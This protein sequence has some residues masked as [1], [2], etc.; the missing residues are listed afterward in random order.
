MRA[1]LPRDLAPNRC[2][3]RDG[4]ARRPVAAPR[5]GG[6]AAFSRGV[7]DEPPPLIGIAVQG[8]ASRAVVVAVG[9]ER[10]F[11]ARAGRTVLQ[12]HCRNADID[13]LFVRAE[14]VPSTS[15]TASWTA[16]SR[17]WT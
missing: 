15:K 5:R 12:S 8:S 7:D 13:L 1:S 6:Y 4:H 10:R 11:A 9:G 16:E 14:D 3:H 17:A 2:L